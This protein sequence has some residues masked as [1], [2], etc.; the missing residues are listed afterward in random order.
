MGSPAERPVAL[1]FT[2]VTARQRADRN[3]TFLHEVSLILV[4]QTSID[5]AMA[6]LT[7]EIAEH[8]A[9]PRVWLAEIDEPSDCATVIYEW[10]RPGSSSA[11]GQH[12][13]S[14]Q[15]TLV[16]DLEL[17]ARELSERE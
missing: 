17:V 16:A 12:R 15:Y 6:S 3:R 10:H 11:A 7:R 4:E 5:E 14:D 9:V 8:F 1:V 13:S 2:D